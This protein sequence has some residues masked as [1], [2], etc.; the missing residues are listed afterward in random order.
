MVDNIDELSPL[1]GPGYSDNIDELSPLQGVT[2]QEAPSEGVLGAI[3]DIGRGVASGVGTAWNVGKNIAGKGVEAA[4]AGA[5]ALYDHPGTVAAGAGAHIADVAK[6]TLTGDYWGNIGKAIAD[7]WGNPIPKESTLQGVRKGTRA[8]A[9]GMTEP[10]ARA[11]E[12]LPLVGEPFAGALRGAAHDIMP[13]VAATAAVPLG[14]GL[15]MLS[16]AFDVVTGGAAAA[17]AGAKD[18]QAQKQTKE[19]LDI[20]TMFLGAGDIGLAAKGLTR[21]AESLGSIGGKVAAKLAPVINTAPALESV[22]NKIKGLIQSKL[23]GWDEKKAEK[24]RELLKN[25]DDAIAAR[26]REIDTNFDNLAKPAQEKLLATAEKEIPR[27]VINPTSFAT[28]LHGVGRLLSELDHLG[29]GNVG[30]GAY[31][32]IENTVRKALADSGAPKEA[33]ETT[34]QQMREHRAAPVDPLETALKGAAEMWTQEEAGRRT[35][36]RITAGEALTAR[37]DLTVE[38]VGRYADEAFSKIQTVAKGAKVGDLYA[39]SVHM[40]TNLKSGLQAQYGRLFFGPA[41][42]KA[43]EAGNVGRPLQPIVEGIDYLGLAPSSLAQALNPNTKSGRLIG[44]ILSEDGPK[45]ATFGELVD[46][47]EALEGLTRSANLSPDLEIGKL[48]KLKSLVIDA[49]ERDHPPEWTEAVALWK[50]G[51]EAYS[52]VMPR[53]NDAAAN[54]MH[55]QLKAGTAPNPEKLIEVL[56]ATGMRQRRQQ[57][58]DSATRA[59]HGEAR[60]PTPAGADMTNLPKRWLAATLEAAIEKAAVV[61]SYGETGWKTV[62]GDKL[63]A[64]V[65]HLM[66]EGALEDYGGKAVA[67]EIYD[68]AK[69]LAYAGGNATLDMRDKGF[70][71]AV[72]EAKWAEVYRAAH[73]NTNPH[74]ALED[75]LTK[76]QGVN[77]LVQLG[78]SSSVDTA[79][80]ALLNPKNKTLATQALDYLETH[81]AAAFNLL[82]QSLTR[83]ILEP[84]IGGGRVKRTEVSKAHEVYIQNLT[85]AMIA[86]LWPNAGKD[87]TTLADNLKLLLGSEIGG[88]PGFAVGAILDKPTISPKLIASVAMGNPKGII[89][90]LMGSRL[91]RIWLMEA[92]ANIF[93]S[94]KLV[95]WLLRKT[96]GSKGLSAD[97]RAAV[98]QIF[99]TAIQGAIYA[100]GVETLGSLLGVISPDADPVAIATPH[101]P[102]YD[103]HRTSAAVNSERARLK[104]GR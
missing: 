38:Q 61:G 76:A 20:A 98:T 3:G 65:E 35:A 28:E 79:V 25:A 5:H 71:K 53:F 59:P 85:P 34:L 97:S 49:I 73:F 54:I 6:Q 91:T 18:P 74:A 47:K 96:P 75:I 13:E 104:G 37:R 69:S 7:P 94:P 42:A 15:N 32:Q 45:A 4:E 44:T 83:Q 82:R 31:A 11:V 58:V 2:K 1:Q 99:S 77:P 36:G 8:V 52:K 103:R 29:L 64:H 60:I 43:I 51:R 92:T 70:V 41:R 56:N 55:D 50:E 81:D 57:M 40:L 68:A 30:K 10:L 22:E 12:Y 19:A 27:P 102:L 89:A 39:D 87:V 93:S 17:L 90:G 21:G 9:E 101:N 63:L 78:M 26:A 95:S 86:R 80:A 14:A 72:E 67:Q 84:F 66:R 100:N 62:N 24:A 88:M 33:I 48:R 23:I 16:G 46:L